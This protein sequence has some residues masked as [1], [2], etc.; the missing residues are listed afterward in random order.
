M[1]HSTQESSSGSQR[2]TVRCNASRQVPLQPSSSS[3][4]ARPA[5]SARSMAAS[6]SAIAA[7]PRMIL[8]IFLSF[9]ILNMQLVR[10]PDRRR[11]A[12]GLLSY[13]GCYGSSAI[14]TTAPFRT[15][16]AP[17]M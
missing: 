4:M 15:W 3:A 7:D 17:L 6:E 14:C 9:P 12:P 11:A 5:A 10:P 8:F 13:R 16:N 1:W 2:V